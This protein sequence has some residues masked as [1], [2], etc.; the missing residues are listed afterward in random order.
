M[1]E[2]TYIEFNAYRQPVA[3]HS[4]LIFES[5]EDM[6]KFFGENPDLLLYRVRNL[7]THEIEFQNID[8]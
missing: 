8:W 1:Y 5:K 6:R 4:G 7:Q 3:T 2:V